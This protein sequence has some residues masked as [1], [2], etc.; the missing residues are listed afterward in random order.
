MLKV[1]FWLLR[2]SPSPVLARTRGNRWLRPCVTLLCAAVATFAHAAV[3]ARGVSANGSRRALAA[4]LAKAGLAV[5]NV[6]S[7]IDLRVPF[8]T[9]SPWGDW[10]SCERKM[11]RLPRPPC[12]RSTS[13]WPFACS[14]DRHRTAMDSWQLQAGCPIPSD[15]SRPRKSSEKSVCGPPEREKTPGPS[16]RCRCGPAT[17]G[18]RC[19]QPHASC[20]GRRMYRIHGRRTPAGNPRAPCVRTGRHLIRPGR[21][22]LELRGRAYF[23]TIESVQYVL[24]CPAG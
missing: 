23:T 12:R 6:I 3:P 17:D 20:N 22:A 2:R 15:T 4:A 13:R 5:A 24:V 18:R 16:H 14:M 19:K 11:H 21:L 1:C 10:S 9:L 7:N 8:I